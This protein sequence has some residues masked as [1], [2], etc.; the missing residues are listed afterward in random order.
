MPVLPLH[1]HVYVRLTTSKK[2]Q[3]MVS[4]GSYESSLGL[5][6][7]IMGQMGCWPT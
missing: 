4:K 3:S 1:V 5:L 7:S 2:D 6:V